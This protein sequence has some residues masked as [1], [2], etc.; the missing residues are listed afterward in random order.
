VSQRRQ[1]GSTGRIQVRAVG[2]ALDEG[3]QVTTLSAV[4]NDTKSVPRVDAAMSEDSL[5]GLRAK[6]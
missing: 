1:I 2:S 4:L 5:G 3:N 6:N